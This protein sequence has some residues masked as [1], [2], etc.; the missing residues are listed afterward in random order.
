LAYH[1]TGQ[2]NTKLALYTENKTKRFLKVSS[3]YSTGGIPYLIHDR[4]DLLV[5]FAVVGEGAN[6]V[7]EGGGCVGHQDTVPLH[8]HLGVQTTNTRTPQLIFEISTT[9]GSFSELTVLPQQSY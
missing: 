6:A 5:V 8:R 1:Q 7:V 4:D 2:L 3:F 9:S